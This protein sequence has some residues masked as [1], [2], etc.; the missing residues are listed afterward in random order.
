[1]IFFFLE[2]IDEKIDEIS[3]ERFCE[4]IQ[5]I[6]AYSDSSRGNLQ[7]QAIKKKN[8]DEILRRSVS[9]AFS[10]YYKRLAEISCYYFL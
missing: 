9:G 2:A 4:G 10:S 7:V 1:M 5:T 6:I 8:C 3:A